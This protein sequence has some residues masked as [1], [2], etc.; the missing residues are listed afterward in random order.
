MK[1]AG[2][3]FINYGI[4]SVDNT[5]LKN[6]K[7]GLNYEKII[8]GIE[9]T[10]DIGISPGLNMLFGNIG[11]SR[12]TLERAVEFLLKYDD[13][14]QVRTIRPVTP[15]P[16]SPMYYDA[17]EKGLL[18]DVEDFYENKHLNSEFISVNFTELSDDEFYDCLEWA[19]KTLLKNY[20]DHARKDAMDKI[21][22]LYRTRDANF[23][24]NRDV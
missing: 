21:E 20:H 19:N 22:H 1:D 18:K 24:G 16:G 14:A 17:I 4:E 23:R 6:M 12:D 7:K 11:D 3:V 9:Q 13:F 2:C 8:S 15:Y 5:V 10:L